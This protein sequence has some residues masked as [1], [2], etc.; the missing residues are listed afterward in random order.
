M[1][2]KATASLKNYGKSVKKIKEIADLIRGLGALEAIA[3]LDASAKQSRLDFIKLIKSALANAKNSVGTINDESFVITE[4]RMGNAPMLKRW[5]AMAYGRAARILRRSCHIYLTI[6]G[7]SVKKGKETTTKREKTETTGAEM[8]T[9]SKKNIDSQG[10]FSVD[11]KVDKKL[12]KTSATWGKK[13]FRR[14]SI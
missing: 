4:V 3:Q 2:V 9:E 1:K 6:E 5:S 11:K 14:K 10:K 8:A 12:E 7:E 13:I